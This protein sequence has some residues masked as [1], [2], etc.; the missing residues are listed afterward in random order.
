MLNEHCAAW[1]TF[2]GFIGGRKSLL[3]CKFCFDLNQKKVEKEN[4]LNEG[5]IYFPH[6]FEI[7]YVF[8]ILNLNLE[9]KFIFY[10]ASRQK[11]LQKDMV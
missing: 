2:L 6:L 7:N 11:V 5:T 4:E 3:T 9:Q 1:E 10:L 8:L